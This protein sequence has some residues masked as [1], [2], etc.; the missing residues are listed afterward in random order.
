MNESEQVL[1]QRYIDEDNGESLVELFEIQR[2]KL[3]ILAQQI[4]GN[5]ADAEDAIQQAIEQLIQRRPQ[6]EVASFQPWL[7]GVVLNQARMIVRRESRIHRRQQIKEEQRIQSM[8]SDPSAALEQKETVEI[9]Q[10]IIGE[11]PQRYREPM[12]LHHMEGM[13]FK[14]IASALDR[15]EETVKKQSQRGMAMMRKMMNGRGLSVSMVVLVGFL[16]D[17]YAAE[18]EV[19][20]SYQ[21]S[22]S[23]VQLPSLLNTKN[24]MSAVVAAALL[25]LA[26]NI[27]F[28]ESKEFIQPVFAQ[29]PVVQEEVIVVEEPL[30]TALDWKRAAY[31]KVGTCPFGELKEVDIP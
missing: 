31:K 16:Q 9:I 19:V 12:V 13:N 25:L 2:P 6:S 15:K 7:I 21:E 30:K 22:A 5:A 24:I 26:A 28:S 17:I 11:L 23:P 20:F 4:T 1:W 27:L 8:P 3:M 29:A 10:S 14:N 18:D